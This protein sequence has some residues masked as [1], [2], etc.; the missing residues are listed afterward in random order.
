MLTD[1]PSIN[2]LVEYLERNGLCDREYAQLRTS[3]PKSTQ[4]YNKGRTPLRAV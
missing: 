4:K 3:S 2:D 1:K